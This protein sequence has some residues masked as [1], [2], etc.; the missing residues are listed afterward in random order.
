MDDL[1]KFYK[2]KKIFITGH[3]GFKGSWLVSV[4]L[5]FGA[6]VTGFSLNDTKRK[7]YELFTD[8]KSV[9]NIY[10]DI[11]NYNKLK[12]SILKSKPQIIF[13]LAAQSLVIDSYLKPFDT[14]EINSLPSLSN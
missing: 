5:N 1:R 2:N 3:T 8:Y 10:D 12:K 9:V 6:Q 13:H 11:L 4:L 14:F 7:N